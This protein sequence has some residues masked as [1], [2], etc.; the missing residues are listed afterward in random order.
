MKSN[1]GVQRNSREHVRAS[2]LETEIRVVI[3]EYLWKKLLAYTRLVS[4]EINGY[5]TVEI[6]GSAI[7]VTDI[8]ILKQAVS[9][10]RAHIDGEDLAMW[11]DHFSRSGGEA[12]SVCL[13]WH[14]HGMMP[15]FWSGVDDANIVNL[16]TLPP[17]LVSL[18]VNHAGDCLCR[19]DVSRPLPLHVTVKPTIELA[20]L[21][22]AEVAQLGEEV[23]SLVSTGVLSLT[24]RRSHMR[25]SLPSYFLIDQIGGIDEG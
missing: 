12:E 9:S 2:H 24:P 15:V 20:G 11:L 22:P 13:Q 18:E 21:S 10:T 25:A 1:L 6:R 5:G 16:L 4:T 3:P 7:H 14:S 8:F 23:A 19:V 17:L